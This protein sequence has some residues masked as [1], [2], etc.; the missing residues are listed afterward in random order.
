M[1]KIRL[2]AVFKERLCGELL[3]EI[4]KGNNT[5]YKL[6][7]VLPEID[8]RYGARELKSALRFGCNEWLTHGLKNRYKLFLDGKTYTYKVV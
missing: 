5:F 6:K 4:K 8:S 1:N 7:K 3:K 2:T